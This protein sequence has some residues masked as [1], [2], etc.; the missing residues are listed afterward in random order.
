MGQVVWK[1]L[2]TQW[3]VDNILC[4]HVRGRGDG[5]CVNE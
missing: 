2:E 5:S 1:V 4:L 3:E